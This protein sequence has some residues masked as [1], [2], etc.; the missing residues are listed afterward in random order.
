[1]HL[2][3]SFLLKKAYKHTFNF[4][5]RSSHCFHVSV[6]I[7]HNH[8]L[9]CLTESNEITHT[10]TVNF[11]LLCCSGLLAGWAERVQSRHE[12]QSPAA[13]TARCLPACSTARPGLVHITQTLHQ[14]LQRDLAKT[15]AKNYSQCIEPVPRN[16][17]NLKLILFSIRPLIE[18]NSY[19]QVHL[20]GAKI[21]V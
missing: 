2:I 16:F 15:P 13:G 18:A 6:I 4:N 8:V 7:N 1:M 3:I 19:C 5:H 12:Q 20:L 17:L 14:I 10:P 11:M 21:K 9:K